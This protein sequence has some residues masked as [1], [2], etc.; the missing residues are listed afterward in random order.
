MSNSNF[1]G[2][3]LVGAVVGGVLGGILGATLVS[4]NLLS[5]ESDGSNDGNSDERRIS[6]KPRKRF[7]G[8]SAQPD[9]ETTRRGLEDKIAQLNTAID[10][11]RQQLTSPRLES[12]TLPLQMPSDLGQSS[13]SR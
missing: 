13:H 2:G 6:D 12:E 5:S 11:A 8:G 10:E 9:I 3:F 1:A 7:L 4:R